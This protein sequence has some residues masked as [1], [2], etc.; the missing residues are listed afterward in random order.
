M[1]TD[2][3]SKLTN[4]LCKFCRSQWVEV[5]SNNLLGKTWY[6]CHQCGRVWNEEP[7]EEEGKDDE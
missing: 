5:Y 4:R 6:L 7:P 1:I 3:E 2:P